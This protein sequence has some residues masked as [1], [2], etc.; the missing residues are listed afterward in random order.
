M[1]QN[2]HF[3]WKYKHKEIICYWCLIQFSKMLGSL[4]S[5]DMYIYLNIVCVCIYRYRYIWNVRWSIFLIF[6]EIKKNLFDV[7]WTWSYVQKLL[8]LTKLWNTVKSLRS[9]NLFVFFYMYFFLLGWHWINREKHKFSFTTRLYYSIL[10]IIAHIPLY[11][12]MK[13]RI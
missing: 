3:C 4:K 12:L 10:F 2:L 13:E 5:W 6:S 8:E 1:L 7:S 9:S 11:S